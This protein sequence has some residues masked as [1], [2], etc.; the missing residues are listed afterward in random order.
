MKQI[1][2]IL[3]TFCIISC[4]NE[5]DLPLETTVPQSALES[6]ISSNHLDDRL[7]TNPMVILDGGL[8]SLDE[9]V[10]EGFILSEN[11]ENSI[12][13]IDQENKELLKM[14]GEAASDGLIVIRT[15]KPQESD[16]SSKILASG[17]VLLLVNGKPTS[18]DGFDSLLPNKIASIQVTKNSSILPVLS[19]MGYEGIVHIQTK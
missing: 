15:I 13:I 2:L 1:S 11:E 17:R 12:G 10:L 19:D 4:A 14:F 7:G 16:Q 8:K 3:L 6:Y 9:L 18:L 5:A